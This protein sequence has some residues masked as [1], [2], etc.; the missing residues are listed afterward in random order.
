MPSDD[1]VLC[2]IQGIPGDRGEKGDSGDRGLAV[3]QL[4]WCNL[5]SSYLKY[6]KFGGSES[7][8]AITIMLADLNLAVWYTI[9]NYARIKI[10]TVERTTAKLF[11]HMVY[12][13]VRASQYYVWLIAVQYITLY[14]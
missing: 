12:Q 7:Q 9:T 13:R 2:C 14:S 5:Y 10:L 4:I 1:S 6:W 8:I 11:G 3:S